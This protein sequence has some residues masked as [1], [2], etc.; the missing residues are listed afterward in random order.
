MRLKIF[1]L[2]LMISSFA[3]KA[4]K[5]EP[6]ATKESITKAEMPF[7]KTLWREME[8]LDYIYREQMYKEV[9][10]NDTIRTLNKN[11]ILELLGEPDYT[12]DGHLYYT[13]SRK[14]MGQWTLHAK[15]VVIKTRVDNTIE[16]IKIHE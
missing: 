11:E 2:L 6:S 13:I 14:R 9:V 3:C 4:D 7:D 5:N 1:L 16:W 12:N 8:D 10:Y 15:T